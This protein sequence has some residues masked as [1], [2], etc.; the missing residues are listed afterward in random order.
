MEPFACDRAQSGRANRVARRYEDTNPRS[1]QIFQILPTIQHTAT[2]IL[3][4]LEFAM[5][6]L[7]VMVVP[8]QHDLVSSFGRA[9]AQV[10]DERAVLVDWVNRPPPAIRCWYAFTR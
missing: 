9:P 6:V 4:S 5:A 2:E 10:I 3:A 7:F 1:D 8:V